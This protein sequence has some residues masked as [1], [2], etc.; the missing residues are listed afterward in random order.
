MLKI[1]SLLSH[2]FT[3]IPGRPTQC[4]AA[5]VRTSSHSFTLIVSGSRWVTGYP[6]TLV[7]GGCRRLDSDVGTV[8]PLLSSAVTVR[9]VTDVPR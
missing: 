4:S 6:G 9:E 3:R 2:N 8:T 1:P 5:S 7:I